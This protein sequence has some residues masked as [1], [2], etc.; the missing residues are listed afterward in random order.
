MQNNKGEGPAPF[1]PLGHGA[2]RLDPLGKVIRVDKTDQWASHTR[3]RDSTPSSVE[4][5]TKF[6]DQAMKIVGAEVLDLNAPS[7]IGVVKADPGREAVLKFVLQ[8]FQGGRQI[9]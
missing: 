1:H 5:N 3:G 8:M 2:R 7:L 6:A 4:R 9:R